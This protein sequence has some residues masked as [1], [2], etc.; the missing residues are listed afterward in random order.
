MMIQSKE[1]WKASSDDL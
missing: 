1:I